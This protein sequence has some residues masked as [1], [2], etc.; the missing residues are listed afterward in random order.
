[1][2]FLYFHISLVALFRTCQHV[3][4][5]MYHTFKVLLHNIDHHRGWVECSDRIEGLCEY[6]VFILLRHCN[7]KVVIKSL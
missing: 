7:W 5:E 3:T 2:A 1:M 4:A 6:R